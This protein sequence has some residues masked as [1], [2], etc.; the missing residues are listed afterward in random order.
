MASVP[1]L[2]FVAA[3]VLLMLVMDLA[4]GYGVNAVPNS[5][6]SHLHRRMDCGVC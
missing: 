3:G 2:V 4:G 6:S 5:I 1:L